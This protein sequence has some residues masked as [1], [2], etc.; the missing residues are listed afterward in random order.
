MLFSSITFLYFFLPC[1]VIIYFSVPKKIKNSVLLFSSL[2]FYGWGEPRYLIFLSAAIIQGYTFGL[3]IEKHRNNKK[4]SSIFLTITVL[5]SLGMLG[6]FKYADFFIGNFNAVFKTEIPLLKIMLPIGISFY[7]FQLLSYSIDIYRGNTAAQHNFINFAAYISMFPQLVAGPI[8]RYSHIASQLKD[9]KHSTDSAAYG[10]KRFVIGLSKKIIFANVLG[11]LTES[12]RNSTEKSVLFAWLF[13]IAYTL[14]V[15]YDFSGYSDMAIGLGRIFGFKFPENFNYPYISR[16]ITDFWRRWHMSLGTW[17]RDYL[18]IPMGGNRV[19]KLRWMFNI[20]IV[21][22]ATGFWHGASWNFI[23][24]GLWFSLLLILEKN[25]L[26]CFLERNKILSHI[27]VFFALIIS[28]VIF[29]SSSMGNAVSMFSSM[30][31]LKG[32]PL[33]GTESIYFLKSYCVIIIAAAFGATPIP[34]M[35]VNK[36][37]RLKYSGFAVSIIEP[38]FLTALLALSTSFLIDGSFNPFLYFRF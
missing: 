28:F 19:S 10:I 9:R 24:W 18:Y 29:D 21:W 31:G 33:M 15:Y 35:L 22:M 4:T 34:A 7:T 8:V 20:L 17:F 1:V 32:T 37:S 16:S 3:F 36:I 14:H 5:I 38:L 2:F 11:E 6:Y 27:Y 23:I 26:R 13:V 30:F 25:F 12:F